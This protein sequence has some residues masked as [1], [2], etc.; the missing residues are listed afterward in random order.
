VCTLLSFDGC[1]RPASWPCRGFFSFENII[2]KLKFS[3]VVQFLKNYWN[4]IHPPLGGKVHF[5]YVP[6]SLNL[7]VISEF[8]I[9]VDIFGGSS[10]LD[11]T[12]LIGI[13]SKGVTNSE[14]KFFQVDS[15]PAQI[16]NPLR[17]LVKL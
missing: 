15:F 1:R 13:I 4:S 2:K 7:N 10:R 3:N 5:F 17:K 12:I 6:G 8:L 14:L 9:C 16:F 11:A